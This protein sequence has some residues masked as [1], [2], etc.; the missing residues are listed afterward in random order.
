MVAQ[1][2]GGVHLNLD[3]AVL[4]VF[5][6]DNDYD[7]DHDDEVNEDWWCGVTDDDEKPALSVH[8]W[9]ATRCGCQPYKRRFDPYC[10]MRFDTLWYEVWHV[11]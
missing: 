6:E 9:P 8:V 10:N 4:K 1:S 7:A 5:D 2:E 11:L 3:V